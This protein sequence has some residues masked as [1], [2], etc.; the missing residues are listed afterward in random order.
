MWVDHQYPRRLLPYHHSRLPRHS[1]SRPVLGGGLAPSF[2]VAE[3]GGSG[4]LLWRIGVDNVWARCCRGSVVEGLPESEKCD[5]GGQVF[6]GVGR[7]VGRHA[8]RYVGI[9]KRLVRRHSQ[10]SRYLGR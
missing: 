2:S 8:R 10:A 5:E 3:V 7:H 6:V 1:D 9:K 4:G